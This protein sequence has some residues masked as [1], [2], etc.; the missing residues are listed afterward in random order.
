MLA[1]D[2]RGRITLGSLAG[3]H[4]IFLANVSADNVI[5]LTPAELIPVVKPRPRRRTKSI[6]SVEGDQ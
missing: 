5:T 3:D 2:A 4:E 1:V 6:P